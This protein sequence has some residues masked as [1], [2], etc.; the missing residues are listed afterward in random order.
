MRSFYSRQIVELSSYIFNG[1]V[2]LAA[3]T[4][5]LCFGALRWTRRLGRGASTIRIVGGLVFGASFFLVGYGVWVSSGSKSPVDFE[6]AQGVNY[7][8]FALDSGTGRSAIG[9]LVTI[10]LTNPCVV[11]HTSHV[12]EDGTAKALKN[13]TWAQR[14][15]MLVSMNGSFF[16]P[17][18]EFPT[19][20]DVT[21]NEGD[22]VQVLGP[23]VSTL[24]HPKP[25]ATKTTGTSWQ[26]IS[27]WIDGEY[28]PG[29]GAD[30]PPSSIWGITGREQILTDGE[31]S[32]EPSEP[33]ARSVIG[34]DPVSKQMWWLVVDGKQPGYSYGA[35]LEASAKLL[36]ERGAV[37]AVEMDG[38][39]SS[40][41]VYYDGA[42]FERLTRPM[43]IRIPGR[44][45]AI[46]NHVGIA[47]GPR[48]ESEGS[49]SC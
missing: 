40:I 12:A 16:Y 30:I 21:P 1:L 31:I 37:D 49:L 8:R 36:A 27:V 7:E 14:N 41:M 29:M 46:A 6:L 26:G 23:T 42:Q 15:S 34:I 33:Y 17:Y 38:G 44:S 20:W 48:P 25:T 3:A 2:G 32:A 5:L 43:Q 18:K 9:H 13:I 45:R 39:G 28:R 10:D 11:L 4:G 19:Y 22:E 47:R 24:G 35:T